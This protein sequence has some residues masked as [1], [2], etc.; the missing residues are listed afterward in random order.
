MKPKAESEE[1][2]RL[3][4]QFNFGSTL[5][6]LGACMITACAHDKIRATSIAIDVSFE[7]LRGGAIDAYVAARSALSLRQPEEELCD[8]PLPFDEEDIA[9]AGAD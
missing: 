5:Y 3:A 1:D 9:L 4:G 7:L 2:Q 8:D 6:S